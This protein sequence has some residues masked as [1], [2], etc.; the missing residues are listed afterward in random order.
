M[1]SHN[2]NA[3]GGNH[4]ELSAAEALLR[5][6]PI[7][8]SSNV[9]TLNSYQARSD[10]FAGLESLAEQANALHSFR[11]QSLSSFGFGKNEESSAFSSKT[12]LCG[13][14]DALA[15]LAAEA[16]SL[17]NLRDLNQNWA[18]SGDAASASPTGSIYGDSDSMPPPPPRG[19][20]RSA[21]NPEGM[22]KWDSYNRNKSSRRHF[23]LPEDILE[24]ELAEASAA[25]QQQKRLLQGAT[26]HSIPKLLEEDD[27]ENDRSGTS[28]NSVV[29][30]P[31]FMDKALTTTHEPQHTADETDEEMD[32]S[33]LLPDELLKRAR[34]RLLEDLSE[35]NMNGEKGVLTL[36]HSLA[37]YKEVYNTN[38]RIGIYTP[39]ERAAIIARFN[40]KRQRRVWNKKIRYNCRK[41]LADRRVRV[42][43]RFVKR[44]EQES[45][46]KEIQA[47]VEQEVLGAFVSKVV[48]SNSIS[49]PRKDDQNTSGNIDNSLVEAKTAIA[50]DEHMPDVDDPDA[51]FAPTEDQPYRRLRR[52]TIT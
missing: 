26:T 44:S 48:E 45:L 11:S 8:G 10:S 29:Q 1:Q 39:A 41:S 28:P 51:G 31:S 36:P 2:Y 38:G 32:E 12:I 16:R 33:E 5:V 13:G 3:P 15:I 22:E 35:G 40:K 47:R 7:A 34:S 6:S 42:K 23:V 43:G 20:R 50:D 25:I 9:S 49:S 18:T 4:D 24:E 27:H 21:S 52:Y 14:L 37:K 46:A 17:S 30:L 19:R